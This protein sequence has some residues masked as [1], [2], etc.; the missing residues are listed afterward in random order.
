MFVC[1]C[2]YMYVCMLAFCVCLCAFVCVN[3]C[4][5]VYVYM[6]LLL[7][8]FLCL[9]GFLCVYLFCVR[10]IAKTSPNMNGKPQDLSL[11][12]HKER[13]NQVVQTF[14]FPEQLRERCTIQ[15]K[16]FS[17]QLILDLFCLLFR[18]KCLLYWETNVVG[19]L[20]HLAVAQPSSETGM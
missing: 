13:S 18:L 1:L 19:L 3:V 14:V 8:L 6:F 16:F 10:I 4:L 15:I 12:I 9:S 11:W 17:I 5:Y 2:V 7:F 20:S